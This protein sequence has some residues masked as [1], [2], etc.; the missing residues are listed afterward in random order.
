MYKTRFLTIICSIVLMTAACGTAENGSAESSTKLKA[1]INYLSLLP[2]NSSVVLYANVHAVR[3]TRM[4]QEIQEELER[5]GYGNHDHSDK[6]YLEFVDKTGLDLEKDVDEI[7]G[8]A[9]REAEGETVAGA[10]VTGRFDE[11]RLIDYM[12]QEKSVRLNTETFRG[13]KLYINEKDDTALV[14]FG[15]NSLVFGKPAWVKAVVTLSDDGGSSVMDNRDMM[16]FIEDVPHKEH[17]WVVVDMTEY[18]D[19]WVEQIRKNEMPFKGT[20]SLENLE[21]FTFAAKIEDKARVFITGSFA[22]PEE[23]KLLAD[24]LNGFKAMGKLMIADDREAVDML[25][26]IDIAAQGTHLTVKTK[27][28]RGFFDKIKEKQRRFS[29]KPTKLL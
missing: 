1:S 8:S 4:G 16:Q 5:K 22:T 28:D 17:F 7:W 21:S 3:K 25:N 15:D 24:M 11:Q 18:A 14:F 23:A 20:K 2:E 29:N 12:T 26:D 9:V 6:D 13:R 10:I 19:E 27:M